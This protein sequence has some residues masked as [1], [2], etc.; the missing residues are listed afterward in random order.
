MAASSLDDVPGGVGRGVAVLLSLAGGLP[1]LASEPPYCPDVVGRSCVPTR[2]CQ[3]V[4]TGVGICQVKAVLR[5]PD[6]SIRSLENEK[7]PAMRG[8]LH[9]PEK[10]RTSTDHTVHK[11]LNPI[12]LV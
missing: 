10:T 8:F 1:R 6:G 4:G 3:K 9:A 5:P 11:A 2:C 12:Q 7:S